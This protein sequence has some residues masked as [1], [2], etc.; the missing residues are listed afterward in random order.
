MRNEKYVNDLK[1][2]VEAQC[3]GVVSCA[4]ILALGG[5]AAVEVVS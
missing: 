4:D 3:K 5:A 2:A 1:A